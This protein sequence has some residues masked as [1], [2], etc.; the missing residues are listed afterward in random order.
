MSNKLKLILPK[1]HIQNSVMELLERIGLEFSATDRSYR[2]KSSD[3]E[4]EAK[5]LRPQNVPR[6]IELGRH[7][8]GFAGHDWIV[9]QGADVA[10]LL[11]LGLDPVRV[12]AAA[13]PS[14]VGR[15]G[16][17]DQKLVVASEYEKLATSY[18]SGKKLNAVFVQTHGATEAMPPEDADIIIDNTATGETLERNNLVI[19][20]EIMKSTTRFICN[21]EALGDP[22]KQ[23]KMEEMTMLMKSALNADKR[24]LLEMNVPGACF[25]KL[26]KDLPCMRAPTVAPLHNEEGFAVKIAV[27]AAEVPKL[28]PM[29][30][31]AGARDILEFKL[32]KII[33]NGE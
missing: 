18:I 15:D 2:P 24:V 10:E 8:C 22:W 14:I 3:P 27:P 5:M 12:V 32:E 11:D 25:E 21:R 33:S 4:I 16:L 28:I 1:G 9:E 30:I 17:A 7:D 31:E 19:M 29:L 26:V 20:D 13:P 6:L 23:K